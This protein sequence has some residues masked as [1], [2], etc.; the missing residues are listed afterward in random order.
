[1]VCPRYGA[2]HPGVCGKVA[3]QGM[4]VGVWEGWG[5][6]NTPGQVIVGMCESMWGRIGNG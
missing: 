1:M 2:G 4:L 3:V 6:P 5:G